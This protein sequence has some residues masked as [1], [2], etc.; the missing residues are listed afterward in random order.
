MDED[1]KCNYFDSNA[2]LGRYYNPVKGDFLTV[3]NVLYLYKKFN[4]DEGI[5]FNALARD[6]NAQHGNDILI[7]DIQQKKLACCMGS[8][9]PSY[10]RDG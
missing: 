8:F 7:K 9:T 3:S 6:Y 5:V 10:R 1:V 2:M 4:I